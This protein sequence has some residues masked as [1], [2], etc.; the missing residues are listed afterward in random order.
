MRKLA[1]SL[2]C[3]FAIDDTSIIDLGCS[4]GGSLVPII[5]N[6]GA[7][8]HYIGLEISAPMREAAI[9]RFSNISDIKVEIRNTDLRHEF[10]NESSSVVLSI[11]TLQFVPIEYRQ[12]ILSKAFNSLVKGGAFILVEKILGRDSE[13]NDM[14]VKLYYDTKGENGY[15]EEQILEK[16]SKKYKD[17][18]DCDNP[19]GF[20]QKNHCQGKKKNSNK[21]ESKEATDSGAVGGGFSPPIGFKPSKFVS[22]SFK[23]TPSKGE[24]KEGASSASSGSYETPAAWAKSTNKKDWRGRSKTQIPGGAFVQVNKKCKTFPY[25]N[26]GDIKALNISKNEAVKEAIKNISKKYNLSESVIVSIL[27]HEYEVLSK[28]GK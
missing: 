17:S 23:G 15:T 28:R 8:N 16:W 6:V 19:K 18:I 11:L 3:E 13:L 7:R 21:I 22:D 2:A 10:P 20:S 5:E 24:F 25:C 4:R 14:F 9:R 12:Q 1:T 27:E 26:Q